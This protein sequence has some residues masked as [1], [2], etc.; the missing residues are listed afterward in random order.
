ML[1]LETD[2]QNFRRLINHSKVF[3]VYYTAEYFDALVKKDKDGN[4]K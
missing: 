4:L 2:I 3:V 1:E